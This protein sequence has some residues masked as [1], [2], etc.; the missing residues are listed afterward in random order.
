MTDGEWSTSHIDNLIQALNCFYLVTSI[1]INIHKSRLFGI[2][3]VHL[4]VSL[5]A[6][7]ISSNFLTWVFLWVQIW[8][9]FPI[10]EKFH[11]MLSWWKAKM[12]SIGER[13][14]LTLLVIG[15]VLICLTLLIIYSK[16]FRWN[17][18]RVVM[19]I[20]W[21]FIGSF[22]ALKF[23]LFRKWRW[24]FFLHLYFFGWKLFQPFRVRMWGSSNQSIL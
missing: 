4:E 15:F 21:I 17:S 11:Y 23:S 9:T 24:W 5:D 8:R 18:S 13:S 14:S 19:Q 7:R 10:V 22:E 3:I 1:K 16:W 6:S 12:V 20:N 2:G